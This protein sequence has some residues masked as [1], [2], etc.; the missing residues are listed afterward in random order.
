MEMDI[1]DKPIPVQEAQ[2]EQAAL[3]RSRGG[4][5][6]FSLMRRTQWCRVTGCM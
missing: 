4:R 3:R 5:E 2:T 6:V 1:Q